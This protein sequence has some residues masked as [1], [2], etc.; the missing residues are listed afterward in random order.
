MLDVAEPRSTEHCV[1]IFQETFPCHIT[2]TS[3]QP[4]GKINSIQ[5]MVEQARFDIVQ[6]ERYGARGGIEVLLR[7][8]SYQNTVNPY[9][10]ACEE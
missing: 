4:E 9:S 1:I 10:C 2:V 6:F 8:F 7:G 5:G 3:I